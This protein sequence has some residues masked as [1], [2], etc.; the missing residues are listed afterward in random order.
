MLLHSYSKRGILINNFYLLLF[1]IIFL[2]FT[3]RTKIYAPIQTES[4]FDIMDEMKTLVH[5]KALTGMG[6]AANVI[7]N[8]V[9]EIVQTKYKGVIFL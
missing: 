6:V 1:L 2:V 4:I 3:Q 9:L 5:E 8:E 7:A